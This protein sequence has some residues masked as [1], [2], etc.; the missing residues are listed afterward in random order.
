MRKVFGSVWLSS[1]HPLRY[2]SVQAAFVPKTHA[3]AEL[4]LLLKA[5]ELSR[6]WP[7]EI[8]VLQL[9]LKK[10]FDHVEHRAAFFAE[11]TACKA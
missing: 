4:F 1:T 7:K 6:E 10:A 5:A 8:V 11:R 3:D 2:E 9:D